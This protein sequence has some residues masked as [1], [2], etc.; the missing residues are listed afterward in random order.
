MIDALITWVKS[1]Y[2]RS[3]VTI[4]LDD[5][6]PSEVVDTSINVN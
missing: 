4:G 6:F 2:M 1:H 5:D 3:Q